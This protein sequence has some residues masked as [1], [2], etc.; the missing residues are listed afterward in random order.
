ME[1]QE[2]TRIDLK[3][4]RQCMSYCETVSSG[5][6][7]VYSRLSEGFLVDSDEEELPK[8]SI[9]LPR[10]DEAGEP[11]EEEDEEEDEEEL[12]RQIVA[13]TAVYRLTLGMTMRLMQMADRSPS[14]SAI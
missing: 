5:Q 12:A 8:T 9:F 4:T 10:L 7:Y 13:T 11:S 6:K 3:R 1:A 2:V 14:R